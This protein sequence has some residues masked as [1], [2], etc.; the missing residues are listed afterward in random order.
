VSQRIAEASRR[1]GTASAVL[2]L[3]PRNL[4]AGDALHV[5][6]VATDNSPWAQHGESRE[7]LLKI[8]TME[9]RRRSLA[10]RW[11]PP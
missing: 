1:S 8:P 2:D 7:L 4:Q 10:R 9:E 11:I 3:A 5:K 6:I